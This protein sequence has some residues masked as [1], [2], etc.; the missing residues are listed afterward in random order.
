MK[1]LRNFVEDFL[2][3]APINGAATPANVIG[4]GNINISQIGSGE[5]STEPICGTKR[6]RK[7]HPNKHN[8]SVQISQLKPT[9][10]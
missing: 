1:H 4:M 5:L 8:K 9:L 3:T 7:I 2:C 10:N 6:L